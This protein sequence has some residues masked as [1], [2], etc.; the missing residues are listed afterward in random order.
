MWR[1]LSWL[2]AVWHARR[3]DYVSQRWLHEWSQDQEVDDGQ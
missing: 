1:A 2:R 3:N